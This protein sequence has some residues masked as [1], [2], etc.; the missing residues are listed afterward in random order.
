M[1]VQSLK[2]ESCKMI[3]LLPI[4]K[5]GTGTSRHKLEKNKKELIFPNYLD[6]LPTVCREREGSFKNKLLLRGSLKDRDQTRSL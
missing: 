3:N 4:S 5:S 2:T 6:K 1:R